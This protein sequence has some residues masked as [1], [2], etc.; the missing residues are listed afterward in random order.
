MKDRSRWSRRE[1]VQM[2]GSTV[3]AMTFGPPL[4]TRANPTNRSA[5]TRFVYVGFG[6]EGA[7]DEGIAV[8]D[9]SG[10]R[11]RL[12]G[13]VESASPSS[14][15]MDAGE[16]FLYAVNEVNEYEG[17]PSGTVE[18][19]AI[20]ATDGSLKLV[21]KQKLSLSATSPRHAAVS[22]DG[23]ALVVAI[24]GGGAYNVLPLGED[25]GLGR[26]SG[27]LKE[28]G[29]GPHDE[30]RS[31]HPQMVVF[32]RSGRVVSADLGTD[33]LNVLKLKTAQLAIVGRYAARAGD[34]PRQLAFHPNGRQLFVANE[35]DASV[36]C[37]EYDE[38]KGQ[39]VGRRA[40]VTTACDGSAGGVVMAVDPA[41][42]FL[43]TS[44][45]RGSGGVSIWK[46]EG[47]T[48]CLQ[49]L[50]IVDEGR[51]RLHELAMTPDGKSLLGLSREDGG[52][53]GWDVR[54]GQID[55]GVQLASLEAP[56]SMALKSL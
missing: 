14:L 41:G 20:D 29:A 45:R 37:Y 11:W 38:D 9:L 22:P 7:K 3:G 39:I 50:Q 43:Y 40:H 34:G 15:A 4:I 51:A 54:N 17:L 48:G 47:N 52:V 12:A 30:Q 27:I 1:F 23:R 10:G 6:G 32:D 36:A 18:A 2:A 26:V 19:Y 49:R 13:V 5:T 46:I 21:N 44:H 24:H 8:F 35:L 28:T 16:R 31:A 33:R 56:V 55:L 53:F 42:E 25:G